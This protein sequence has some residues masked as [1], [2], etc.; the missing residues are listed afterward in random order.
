[1]EK[2]AETTYTINE[3]L[4]RRWSPRAFADKPVETEKLH[5]LF[6]AA[7]WAPSSFN[8]QPW[9]FIVALKANE[10]QHQRMVDVL[11]EGNRKW[12]ANVP[13][14]ILS[15][16]KLNFEKNDKENLHAWHDVGLAAMS[17]VVQA[18]DLGL[19]VHQM[20]GFDREK[21]RKTYKVPEDHQPVA[22]IAIGYPGDPEKLPKD[23]QEKE[24]SP[25][26]RK[27]FS[28]FVFT[29]QWGEPMTFASRV[30]RALEGN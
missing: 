21:A 25:R 20:A 9:S 27:P 3:L 2:P 23:L 26:V 18:T 29:G 6:E 17:L 4:R 22:V 7:R 24:Y 1:M 8:E 11:V 15:V 19:F 28:E 5:R 16:A 14:L 30:R 13:V 10:E 12:A